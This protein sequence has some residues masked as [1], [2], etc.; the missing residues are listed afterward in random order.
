MPVLQTFGVDV[1]KRELAI[2]HH[3]SSAQHTITNSARAISEWL[4]QFAEPVQIGVESTGVYHQQLAALA[5]AAGHRVYVL[6]PRRLKAYRKALGQRAKTD[7]CDAEL[8]AHYLAREYSVLHAYVPM[9]PALATLARLL[10]RRARIV[11][12]RQRLQATLRDCPE[13]WDELRRIQSE[14][15]GLLKGIDVRCE[16]LIAEDPERSARRKRLK[17]IPGIGP[18]TSSALLTMLERIPY[19]NSDALVAA[20]GLDPRP[21]D[22]GDR[23]GRRSITKRGSSDLRRLLYNAATAAARESPPFQAIYRRYRERGLNAT[24][25]LIAIAR[26]LVRISFALDRSGATFDVTRLGFH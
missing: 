4:E 2:A 16:T 23:R 22:S 17:S 14:I 24:T 20:T 18:Q 26:K 9:A 13:C 21:N 6:D 5:Q 19:E 1:G 7:R 12:C 15:K 10:R 3:E 25:A 11:V 8:I